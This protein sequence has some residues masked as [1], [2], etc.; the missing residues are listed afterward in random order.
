ME[1]GGN[2]QKRHL[3]RALA[4]ACWPPAGAPG[5]VRIIQDLLGQSDM[6]A[7]VIYA[8]GLSRGLYGLASLG[9]SL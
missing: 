3:L 5:N 6:Q 2:K 8:H 4:S 7:A 1:G 9:V